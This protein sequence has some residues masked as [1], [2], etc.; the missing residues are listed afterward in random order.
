MSFLSAPSHPGLRFVCVLVVLVV[1]IIP[2]T[3]LRSWTSLEQKLTSLFALD[4]A[5]VKEVFEFEE[6][7]GGGC[8]AILKFDV[9]D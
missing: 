3:H 7:A 9:S 4:F 1:G 6:L 8:D 2:F 5:I